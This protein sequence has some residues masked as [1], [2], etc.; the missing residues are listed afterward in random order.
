MLDKYENYSKRELVELL[1]K[2]EAE[3]KLGLVW[4]RDEIEHERLLNKAFVA[5]ELDTGLSVG[6]APYKDLL[7]EGDNFDALRFLQATY[8]GRVK[9]IYI[10]PPYNTGNKD[11]IYKD[12]YVD[13]D[14]AFK[15][16]MWLEF[17]Y[18][19][20]M[21][22]KDL[23]SNDGVIFISIGEDEYANLSLLMEKVFP[24]KRVGSFVWRRRSGANDEKEWFVSIDH[25]Y[26]LCYA[27]KG[28]SFAGKKKD[29]SVYSNPDNDQRGDWNNDNLV[30]AH[31]F[32]QRPD[33]FYPIKNPETETWY[34]AD[35]DN[36]WR[37]ATK[38][39]IGRASCRGR[40]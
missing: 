26:V 39:Q 37:F 15:H 38:E 40:V 11:F 30:K 13:K 17:M 7:I 1:R 27:N 10:D 33:A 22:A 19:R 36:V 6:Q 9:C 12:K 34:P 14:H 18:Q 24:G 25:E 5:L 16:S 31:N 20:L 35:P 3:R 2:R 8:K 28:F 29:M 23:L 21:L 32:K 4:E